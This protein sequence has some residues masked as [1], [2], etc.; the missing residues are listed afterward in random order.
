DAMNVHQSQ[1]AERRPEATRG[2]EGLDR[3]KF[4]V[5]DCFRM[6]ETGILS[7]DY[8]FELIDGELV[9]MSPKGVPHERTKSE[10]TV[11]WAKRLPDTAK[12]VTATTLKLDAHGFRE[13]DFYFWPMRVDIADKTP[14]DA[15]LI[16]EIASSSL[17]YDLGRKARTY[18]AQSVQEYWVIDA[19]AAR[20]AVM[21]LREDGTY[22]DPVWY[23]RDETVTPVAI[24]ELAVCL[25][26]LGLKPEAE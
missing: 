18:E 14:A 12:M 20:I 6:V 19:P 1:F 10:L 7:H 17:N 5:D 8:R 16:V 23:E 11:H 25:S 26:D 15:L 3:H 4:T 9:P 21:R 24:P 13:P 22:G 2:A